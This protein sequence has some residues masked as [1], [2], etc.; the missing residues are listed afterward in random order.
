[1]WAIDLERVRSIEELVYMKKK[2]TTHRKSH[3]GMLPQSEWNLPDTK[4]LE[5]QY[6][7]GNSVLAEFVSGHDHSAVLREL[8][9]NEYDA[10]GSQLKVAFGTDELR[11]SGNGNQIDSDGWER[12]SVM[13]GTGQVGG[14][15]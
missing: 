15:E 12:L 4:N 5:L 1:M 7:Y 13:L 11:I 14:S 3:P 8:V 9:Q 2:S 10:F 6:N